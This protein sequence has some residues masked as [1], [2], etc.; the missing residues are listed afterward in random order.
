MHIWHTKFD[1]VTYIFT[2]TGLMPVLWTQ[3]SKGIIRPVSVS[4]QVTVLRYWYLYCCTDTKITLYSD[5]I[6]LKWYNANMIFLTDLKIQKKK[7]KKNVPFFWLHSRH[8]LAEICGCIL[9]NTPI[10]IY[11]K[12][13]LQKPKKRWGGSNE[14]SQSIFLSRN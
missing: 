11:R 6:F 3:I 13:H 9:E 4:V 14:Y 5:V 12:F 1:K 10:Q 7:K 2:T 8:L